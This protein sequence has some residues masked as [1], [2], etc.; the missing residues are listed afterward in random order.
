MSI[1]LNWKG[2]DLWDSTVTIYN[3]KIT[4]K[5]VN[6]KIQKKNDHTKTARIGYVVDRRRTGK[7]FKHV[8]KKKDIHDFTDV[9]PDWDKHCIGIESIMLDEG[10]DFADGLY[11]HYDYEKTGVIRLSAWPD[12][13][14][15]DFTEIYFQEHKW[16]FDLFGVVYE[17]KDEDWIVYF[18]DNQ[19]KAF[20]LLHVFLHELGHH[21][22]KLRSRNEDTM[23]G[24]EE[25]AEKYA[26][27]T[28]VKIWASYVKKFGAL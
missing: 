17:Q 10:S 11:S 5:V 8:L 23:N 7:G 24:G 18:T 14:A 21:I 3:R 20:M 26:N 4:P 28:C 15:V 2:Y 9:I 19:A 6:G 12:D 1:S 13:M 16:L 27:D 25:F 22:D